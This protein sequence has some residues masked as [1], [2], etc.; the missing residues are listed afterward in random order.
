M[1]VSTVDIDWER[2]KTG[3]ILWSRK[4]QEAYL[5]TGWTREFFLFMLWKLGASY[6]EYLT[7]E[8]KNRVQEAYLLRDAEITEVARLSGIKKWLKY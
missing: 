1:T 4:W 6:S 3:N 8:G 5:E 2:L 7:E